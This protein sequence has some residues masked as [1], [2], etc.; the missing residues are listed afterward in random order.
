MFFQTKHTMKKM[1][2]SAAVVVVAMTA[3]TK[4]E[5][6]TV[7]KRSYPIS[8]TDGMITKA[9]A[10][11]DSRWNVIAVK[12][13][14]GSVD[15]VSGSQEFLDV[16]N[17]DAD[18]RDGCTYDGSTASP[19]YRYYDGVNTY[20]FICWGQNLLGTFRVNSLPGTEAAYTAA[21]IPTISFTVP[22]AAD[23]DLVK[24]MTGE[25]TPTMQ[26]AADNRV[27]LNFFHTLSKVRFTF[28]TQ[29]YTPQQ[30]IVVTGL[31]FTVDSKTGV[32][33]AAA[34]N[35]GTWEVSA[36][37]ATYTVQNWKLTPLPTGGL[38]TVETDP[39]AGSTFYVMPQLLTAAN[40]KIDLSYTINGVAAT[41][42]IP[43]NTLLEPGKSYNYQIT[44]DLNRID[45]TAQVEDWTEVDPISL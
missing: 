22:A 26:A 18:D 42:Q 10:L 21:A 41:K 30:P 45:F 40:A 43:L 39:E 11:T 7:D 37:P 31:S 33:S 38:F 28:R 14:A 20:K 36:S 12:G 1:I 27:A 13:T 25:V 34:A 3:C 35:S 15:Y 44:I 6:G 5:I 4:S 19:Q 23:V 8:F 17:Y 16:Y 29:T 2:L 24:A 9:T 32:L